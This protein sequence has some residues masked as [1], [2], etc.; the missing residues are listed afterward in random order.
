[1][2]INAPPLEGIFRRRSPLTPTASETTTTNLSSSFCSL[3]GSVG[4]VGT[5]GTLGAEGVSG[6]GD[7]PGAGGDS[8]TGGAPGSGAGAGVVTAT[9]SRYHAAAKPSCPRG[10]RTRTHWLTA[11]ILDVPSNSR[12]MSCIPAG[13]TSSTFAMLDV[14]TLERMFNPHVTESLTRATRAGTSLVGAGVVVGG[15]GVETGPAGPEPKTS[16]KMTCEIERL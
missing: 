6:V 7:V 14:S 2:V 9:D 12:R 13:T 4:A 15:E 3:G 16:Y 10:V 5:L 8:L 11:P 1:M